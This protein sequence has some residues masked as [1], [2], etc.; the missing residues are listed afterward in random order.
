MLLMIA[1]S[2]QVKLLNFLAVSRP[3]IHNFGAGEALSALRLS[4][5]LWR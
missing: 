3:G 1:L 2:E 4:C 5:Q